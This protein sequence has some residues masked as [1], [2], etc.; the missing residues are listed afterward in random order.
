MG[1]TVQQRRERYWYSRFGIEPPFPWVGVAIWTA[2]PVI[3]AAAGVAGVYLALMY[4][5]D[6]IVSF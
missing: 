1:K 2:L 3:G 5:G 6:R 4:G